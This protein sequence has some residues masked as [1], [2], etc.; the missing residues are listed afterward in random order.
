MP[1]DPNA[2]I[3]ITALKW[4]PE[5]AHGLVRDLRVRWALEE[6]GLSYRERL[7]DFLG[8]RSADDLRAQPFGQ[9][10]AYREGDVHLFESGA[11]VL[12]LAQRS[13]ALMPSAHPHPAPA[14]TTHHVGG[15]G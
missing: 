3:E 15:T 8:E 5:M 7:L 11:I 14:A 2:E 9:V 4:V 6:A 13:H 1:V 12:P 10:P